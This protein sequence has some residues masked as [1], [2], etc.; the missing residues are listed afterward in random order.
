MRYGMVLITLIIINGCN[1]NAFADEQS[2]A[3][4]QRGKTLVE[5]ADCISCH[6]K[7]GGKPFAG[8]RMIET[9]FGNIY[10]PNLT[11]DRETGIGAWSDEDFYNAMHRGIRPDGTKL[12]PAFPYPYFTKLTRDDVSAIRAYLNTLDSVSNKRLDNALVWP[13]NHRVFMR[14][15]NMLFFEEGTFVPNPDKSEEWNR[16]AYLVK[17]AAHCGACHTPKNI[18][19][20]DEQDQYLTGGLIQDWYAPSLSNVDRTG[21]G[22]WTIDDIVEYLKTGRNARSGATGLMSEVVANS[23]SKMSDTDLRAIA[24]YLKDAPAAAEEEPASAKPEQTVLDAGKAVYVDSCSACHRSDGTGVPRM[25]PPLQRNANVQS[26]DPTSIIRV[27]LEGA[28]TVTTSAQP[29]PS[30]MPAYNWKLNDDAIAAVATYVRNSWGNSASTVKSSDTKSLR[31]RLA[32][33]DMKLQN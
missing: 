19:G 23:T 29:T 13:L 4:I 33:Q 28:H 20:A 16:G 3:R 22:S 15:W 30:A 17:G 25:F 31:D 14:G 32:A 7:E 10:S 6:T 8:G 26:K 11:P 2:F 18:L 24:I 9:P 5:A 1:A 21:I 27:I 12:Y